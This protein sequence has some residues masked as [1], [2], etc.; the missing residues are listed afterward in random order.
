MKK[1]KKLLILTLTAATSLVVSQVYTYPVIA[2][3]LAQAQT[4]I[5]PTESDE[6]PTPTGEKNATDSAKPQDETQIKSL[7]D[8]LASVVAEM[9]K[10]DQKVVAGDLKKLNGN[11]IE[12]DTVFGNTERAQFDDNLTKFYR[13][14]GAATEEIK[15]TDIKE[16]Q[17]IIVTGPHLDGIINANEIYV[18]EHF[19]SRAGRITEVDSVNYTFKL[20]TFEKDTL[21][22]S[23]EKSTNQ[24]YLNPASKL[25]E[26]GG[27]AKI[28]EGD[29]AHIVYGVTSIKDQKTNITPSRVFIIP[30]AYF[31]K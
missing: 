11:T 1:N 17:Y 16:K 10:K 2:S 5:T 18:D 28:K 6:S 30:A 26:A 21:T 29:I 12:V 14:V 31:V 4:T 27:F 3:Q 8:K 24:E 13:I 25:I 23:V 22:V 19:E 15:K 9:R 7:R 20:E